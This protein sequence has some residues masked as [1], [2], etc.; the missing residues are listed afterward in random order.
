MLA[1][2][3]ATGPTNAE[4]LATD[5]VSPETKLFCAL[6]A[7][8]KIRLAFPRR[9]NLKLA[10]EG[11]FMQTPP[12]KIARCKFEPVAIRLCQG[13][14]SLAP[15]MKWVNSLSTLS[16]DPTGRNSY[17]FSSSSILSCSSNFPPRN[18]P[19]YASLDS[20]AELSEILLLG[21]HPMFGDAIDR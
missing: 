7:R 10:S 13:Y 21:V 17:K 15:S 19:G 2:F 8:R 9:E 16:Y 3:D 11:S 5:S 18:F 12:A 4:V 14:Y 1:K 20:T 6:L